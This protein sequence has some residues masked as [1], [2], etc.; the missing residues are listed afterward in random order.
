[1]PERL[2]AAATAYFDAIPHR[3]EVKLGLRSGLVF[4]PRDVEAPANVRAAL[5]PGMRLWERSF[6]VLGLWAPRSPLLSM[7]HP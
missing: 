7:L 6:S 5:K 3:P 4:N 1:M 2:H